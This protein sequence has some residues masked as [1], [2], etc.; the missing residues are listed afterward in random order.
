MVSNASSLLVLIVVN[1][2]FDTIDQSILLDHLENNVCIKR[3][4]LL[5]FRSYFTNRTELDV[6]EDSK[7]KHC[8]LSF[9]LSQGSVLLAIYMPIFV[10]IIHSYG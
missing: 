5:W 7:S 9:C 8:N 3:L 4:A 6:S 1:A 10:N 2:A